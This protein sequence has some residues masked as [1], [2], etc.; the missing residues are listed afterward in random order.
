MH[1][2]MV[3]HSF[4]RHPGDFA[5]HFLW[6]L[7]EAL[8]TRGHTVTA[9]A[10]ADRGEPGAS[11]LGHVTVCRV[12]YATPH[13]ETLAYH[14]T[15]H[16]RAAADPLA[17]LT[18]AALVRALARA[19]TA[20]CRTGSV[21]LVHAHWWVPAGLATRLA[22]TNGRPFL[23]T[24]HGTDVALA[25]RVPGGRLVM[26][27]V[28]RR[29]AAVT[30]VSSSLAAAAADI[31]GGAASDIAV[32]PM[33]LAPAAPPADTP[34]REGAIF[35]GR[36]TAQKHVADLLEALALLR[37]RGEAPH[38]TVVGDG[39]ERAALERRAASADLAGLVSF[40]GMVP[41]DAVPALLAGKRVCVLPSVDEGLGLVVAEA[42]VAGVPVV[43]AR[44][45][46]IPDL[47]TDP[48]S[49][50]LV[51]PADPAALAEAIHRVASDGRYLAGA[52]RAGR[53][54]L[55]RLSPDA[56]ARRFED[57]YSGVR[58]RRS[59]A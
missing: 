4:P 15:M 51:P 53:A 36:L 25:R 1:V 48:E 44:S 59:R 14:G 40:T 35:V 28:L 37:R 16:R 31:T 46:G 57:V 38:L 12:R 29:A 58:S 30:A 41:P 50:T 5:G 47:L 20:E 39:P 32:E 11:A 17:A 49:G 6:Q 24:L 3:A 21:D 18:F 9:I 34:L 8:A 2:V 42:L 43:A 13:R 26:R 55:E 23:V 45:G 56:V 52:A 19:V 54:L 10:P 22:D 33:P 7:A 27:W